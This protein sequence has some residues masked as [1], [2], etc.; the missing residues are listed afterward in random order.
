[1]K[2]QTSNIKQTFNMKSNIFL[3]IL[4]FGLAGY[5]F[6]S[7]S[8]SGKQKPKSDSLDS[9]KTVADSLIKIEAVVPKFLVIKGTNVN[10]R[11]DPG[12]KA[13]KIRQLKSNDTCAI[14][15]KGKLDSVGS[16]I[17]YWYKIKYKTK[18]GWVFGEFTS[19]KLQ[20]EKNEKPKIFSL[21][22]K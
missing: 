14:L 20:Q 1:M 18:E 7:C 13:K 11:V 9:A 4:I 3:S 21:E 22:K 12:V 6:T 17:D 10:M 8:G 15:E 16:S 5:M 19:L 2:H